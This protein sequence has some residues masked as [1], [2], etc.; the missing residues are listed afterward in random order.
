MR[1]GSRRGTQELACFV[2]LTSTLTCWSISVCRTRNKCCRQILHSSNGVSRRK[3]LPRRLQGHRKRRVTTQVVIRSLRFSDT[4]HVE[5]NGDSQGKRLP[6]KDKHQESLV[7]YEE[8][9][10]EPKRIL[11]CEC[12]CND[13]SFPQKLC[14]YLHQNKKDECR[15][16]NVIYLWCHTKD[17][18]HGRVY[19]EQ[20]DKAFFICCLLTLL[21]VY[22]ESIKR[23]LINLYWRNSFFFQKRKKQIK[24][25]DSQ[26]R[27]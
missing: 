7:Y 25:E 17:R 15:G 10:L 12:R 5:E 23:K 20:D 14:V 2:V 21:L 27:R 22:Y 13:K 24:C 4:F 19:L 8:T 26:S 6:K 3:R 11:V 9:K 18:W 1:V 16:K